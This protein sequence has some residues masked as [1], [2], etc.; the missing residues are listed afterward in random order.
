MTRSVAFYPDGRMFSQWNGG[1][2]GYRKMAP[3]PVFR[4]H[5]ETRLREKDGMTQSGG[6]LLL[7]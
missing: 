1:C 4:P 6:T 5:L 3:T 7:A 2:S